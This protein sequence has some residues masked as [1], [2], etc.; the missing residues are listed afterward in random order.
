MKRL[1][2]AVA[3]AVV[4]LGVLGSGTGE[5]QSS[6]WADMALHNTGADVV[7]RWA[8]LPR[9]AWEGYAEEDGER[10]PGSVKFWVDALGGFKLVNGELSPLTTEDCV[11]PPPPPGIR[12]LPDN[13][14][15][16]WAEVRS[17][18]DEITTADGSLRVSWDFFYPDG[19]AVIE[20]DLRATKPT[21]NFR[22]HLFT[23]STQG[24]M[25]AEVEGNTATCIYAIRGGGETTPLLNL[26]S[27]VRLPQ[28]NN[29]DPTIRYGEARIEGNPLTIIGSPPPTFVGGGSGGDATDCDSLRRQFLERYAD[30]QDNRSDANLRRASAASARYSARC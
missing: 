4:L 6:C 1:M 22:Q 5:V 10:I 15:F 7:W 20:N 29:W 11:G 8:E 12:R 3:A 9:P 25:R 24:R 14:R 19:T 27:V 13:S 23:L 26:S 2:A 16:G 17:P 18:L 28:R 30:W 21:C